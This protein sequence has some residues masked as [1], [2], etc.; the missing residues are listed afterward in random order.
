M[1]RTIYIINAI[2]FMACCLLVTTTTPK[3]K[4]IDV[5]NKITY[6]NSNALTKET[7]EVIPVSVM[8]SQEEPLEEVTIT[9]EETPIIEEKKEEVKVDSPVNNN[10]NSANDNNQQQITEVLE[11]FTGKMSGYGADIGDYTASEHYI[12]DSIYY[13]DKEYGQ[14]R[15]LSGG[16]EYPYGTI[17]RVKNSNVGT[18]IGIVLDRGPNIGKDRKF[19]FDLLFET[20]SEALRYGTS[21]NATFE[22]L[23]IGY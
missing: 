22:I 23:R 13:N 2:L 1:K 5:N 21:N 16:S 4:D 3:V 7:P 18:F 6:V 19:V 15:I 10:Q 11:T 9:K 12:G 17:V 20:S 8:E 14:I